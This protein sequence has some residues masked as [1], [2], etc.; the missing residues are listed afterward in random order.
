MVPM[1]RKRTHNQGT[2][3]EEDE[4]SSDDEGSII[5]ANKEVIDTVAAD[6]MYRSH[7]IQAVS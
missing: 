7:M 2:H 4:D 3:A 5:S 6:D 1:V